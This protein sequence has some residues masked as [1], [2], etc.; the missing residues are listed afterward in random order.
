MTNN[1]TVSDIVIDLRREPL[2]EN[3]AKPWLHYLADRIDVAHKREMEAKDAMIAEQ[4]S[5]NESQAAQLR[6]AL[7]ECEELK[8]AIDDSKRVSDAVIKSLRDEKLEM[9]REIAAKD[10][11]ITMLKTA[12]IPVLTVQ[13][14]ANTSPEKSAHRCMMAVS[15][16]LRIWSELAKEREVTNV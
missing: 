11:E 8:Y 2:A 12:L 16:T 10:A 15:E 9:A 13:V 6:D 14:C 5:V 3:G 7:N 4:A 1:E